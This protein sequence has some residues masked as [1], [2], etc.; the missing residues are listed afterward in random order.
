MIDIISKYTSFPL[1]LIKS[2]LSTIKEDI[3]R[4]YELNKANADWE[5]KSEKLDIEIVAS[6]PEIPAGGAHFPKF[7]IWTPNNLDG[8]VAFF[9]NYQDG[10]HTTK[11]N[12]AKRYDRL[13]IDLTFSNKNLAVYPAYLFQ[14]YGGSDIE[15]IIYSMND[16]GPWKFYETGQVQDFENLEHYSKRIK[17]K[18]MNN[19]IILEY[20]SKIGISIDNSFFHSEMDAIYF[21]RTKW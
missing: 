9:A 16:G 8:W 14:Y 17:N 7:V 21:E 12:L 2:D 10:L 6:P 19:D 3:H 4:L 11:W 13:V 5:I 15:R 18:R 20:L 1:G